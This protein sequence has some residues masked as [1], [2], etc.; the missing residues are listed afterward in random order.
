MSM[1]RVKV[2]PG[3]FV[4]VSDELANKAAKLS[5]PTKAQ[6]TAV[7]LLEPKSAGGPMLGNKLRHRRKPK[8]G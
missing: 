7:A 1:K 4:M 5:F 6:M 2:A 8:R 3:K